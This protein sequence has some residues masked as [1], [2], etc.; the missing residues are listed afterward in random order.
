MSPTGDI[1]VPT[2][3]RIDT[4]LDHGRRAEKVWTFLV[5]RLVMYINVGHPAVRLARALCRAAS[6]VLV[7]SLT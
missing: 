3:R 6:S 5:P 1:S 2:L 7:A 4:T